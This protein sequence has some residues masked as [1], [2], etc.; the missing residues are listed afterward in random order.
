MNVLWYLLKSKKLFNI[1]L[2]YGY[3][4]YIVFQVVSNSKRKSQSQ[5]ILSSYN[6][7]DDQHYKD[8]LDHESSSVQLPTSETSSS[9]HNFQTANNFL[10][11]V[12]NKNSEYYDSID[13]N[14]NEGLYQENGETLAEF[15]S[16][17]KRTTSLINN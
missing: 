4:Y 7:D 9:V 3:Y 6:S 12:T 17:E 8:S 16:L 5:W 10:W 2:F 14:L 1:K 13:S 11:T 15:D